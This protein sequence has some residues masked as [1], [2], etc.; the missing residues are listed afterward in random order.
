MSIKVTNWVW[1]R[2][3]S[4]NGA[5]LVLLAL[6]DR[7]DDDG[8]CW[9]SIDDLMARTKLTRRAVQKGVTALVEGGELE[10]ENGGGRHRSN[11]YRITPK[12]CTSDG[13]TDGKQRT[14][15]AVSALET[16]H[17][18]HETAHF[19]TETAHSTPGNPVKSAPEPSVEPS[20]EPSENPPPSE[21]EPQDISE[22]MFAKWWEQYGRTTAQG[23]ATIRRAISDALRNGLEPNVLWQALERLGE[24]SKPVTGG[25]LQFALSEIRQQ[26]ALPAAARKPATSDLRVQ[27]A[28]EAGRRLQA[29][30]DAQN[31]EHQ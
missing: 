8:L 7:A 3:E 17:F 27:Q 25:T 26:A 18:A 24:L 10:V 21:P 9:P 31:Q 15:D 28:I 12:P 20:R 4:R 16:A 19:A 23:K 6:A 29:L 30:A 2:S 5:R 11:R 14:S 22:Q 1:A 13:V